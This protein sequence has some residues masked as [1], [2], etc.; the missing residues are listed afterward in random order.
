M[1]AP[2]AQSPA[3]WMRLGARGCTIMQEQ[4]ALLWHG[5][6]SLG[7]AAMQ[8][9]DTQAVGFSTCCVGIVS[10]RVG[11]SR[12]QEA[13]A[14]AAATVLRLALHTCLQGQASLLLE[15][16][17]GGCARRTGIAQRWR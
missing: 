6:R 9:A 11:G 13:G 2:C 12:E 17:E 4:R 3:A 15:Q 10:G 16:P 7:S 5:T 14:A 1:F 8:P